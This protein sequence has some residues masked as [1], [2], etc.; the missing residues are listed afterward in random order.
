MAGVTQNT[1]ISMGM[2]WALSQPVTGFSPLRA[3]ENPG[4][5]LS[6]PMATFNRVQYKQFPLA[7]AALLTIDFYS[8][9][10]VFTAPMTTT[11][12]AA[13]FLQVTG[14]G[15]QMKIA[16][17]TTNALVWFF[18]GTSPSL[19]FPTGTGICLGQPTA[20]VVDATHRNFDI[21]NPGS[22]AGTYLLGAGL[23]D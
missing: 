16:P 7:P 6:L 13:L 1:G 15:A 22:G 14:T 21:S 9:L 19:T 20:Q 10:D 12:I 8:W 23:G 11:K 3:G 4:F 18:G 2:S 5:S 17:G